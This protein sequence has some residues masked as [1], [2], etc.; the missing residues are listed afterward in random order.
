MFRFSAFMLV[1]IAVQSAEA[2]VAF[3]YWTEQTP[4]WALGTA[5]AAL[6]ALVLYTGYVI[7]FVRCDRAAY[8]PFFGQTW[9]WRDAARRTEYKEWMALLS[10]AE[11]KILGQVAAATQTKIAEKRRSKKGIDYIETMADYIGPYFLTRDGVLYSYIAGQPGNLPV[12][13]FETEEFKANAK[14]FVHRPTWLYQAQAD[15]FQCETGHYFLVSNLLGRITEKSAIPEMVRFDTMLDALRAAKKKRRSLGVGTWCPGGMEN[16]QFHFVDLFGDYPHLFLLGATGLGKSMDI[17]QMILTLC[18]TNRKK[19]FVLYIVDP[20]I[21]FSIALTDLPHLALPV[22][23]SVAGGNE[24]MQRLHAEMTRRAKLFGEH[25]ITDWWLWNRKP[26]GGKPLPAILGVFDEIQ[27]MMEDNENAT[28]FNR[29]MWQ[30]ASLARRTGIGIVITTQIGLKEVVATKIQTHFSARGAHYCDQIASVR[31]IGNAAAARI[32][33][34]PGRLIFK[35]GAQQVEVQAPIVASTYKGWNSLERAGKKERIAAGIRQYVE[36]IREAEGAA[37][38]YLLAAGAWSK[39]AGQ[40]LTIA[41]DEWPADWPDSARTTG[42]WQITITRAREELAHTNSFGGQMDVDTKIQQ[43][44]GAL[45]PASDKVAGTFLLHK[46]KWYYLEI[47]ANEQ[48]KWQMA[49]GN[50]NLPHPLVPHPRRAR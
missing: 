18:L 36:K 19:D 17:T 14:Q 12:T 30:I 49:N 13:Q 50:E 38:Q 44:A 2:F 9:Y 3:A 24:V 31:A 22:Q 48:D 34:L 11:E 10:T 47:A 43:I 33:A 41:P 16:G 29:Q 25:G 45:F 28:L 23:Q 4:L 40:K 42:V 27:M 37:P 20:K 26:P 6:L 1:I 5:G 46:R 15:E 35:E 7:F 8:I 32:A 39:R 21:D